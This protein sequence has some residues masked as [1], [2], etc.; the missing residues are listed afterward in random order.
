MFLIQTAVRAFRQ[1]SLLALAVLAL[2]TGQT[3]AAEP[4]EIFLKER[5]AVHGDVVTLGDLFENAGSAGK[6][7][8][9]RS[10]DLGTEGFVAATRV[11]RAAAQHGL[12]WYNRGQ[13]SEVVVKR[14]VREIR[15]D[16]IRDLILA[17]VARELSLAD[18]STIDVQLAGDIKPIRLDARRTAPL[19]VRSVRVNRDSGR[20]DA[21]LT[22]D[23]ADS[24]RQDFS[25]QGRVFESAETVVPT[26]DIERGEIVRAGDVRTVRL[27]KSQLISSGVSRPEKL[28]GM[29][30]RRRLGA[31]RQVRRSDIEHPRIVRR[32]DMVTITYRMGGL[33]LHAEGRALADGARGDIISVRNTRSRQ[34]L[35]VTVEGPK[36]VTIASAG[37]RVIGARAADARRN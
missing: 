9:F 36:H 20:L 34:V 19:V 1:P 25:Y 26:R 22:L 31:G 23:D 24:S 17:A 7:A 35:E 15:V 13:I 14:P 11:R 5:I 2:T 8:V 4:L 28:I 21:T 16:E 27:Q 37:G 10:P 12:V 6:I 18:R 30:A 32:N 33:A 3:A 29:A